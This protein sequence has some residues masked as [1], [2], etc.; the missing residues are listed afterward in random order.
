MQGTKEIQ[1]CDRRIIK[2]GKYSAQEIQLKNQHKSKVEPVFFSFSK[3]Y[4]SCFQ[5]GS[6]SK[7]M[8]F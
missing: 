5:N 2:A 8:F 7:K 3:D 1:I 6:K 4:S